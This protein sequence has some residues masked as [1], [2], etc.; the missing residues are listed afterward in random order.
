MPAE[1]YVYKKEVDWFLFNYGLN[2]PIQHQVKFKQIAGRFIE[3]DHAVSERK[4]L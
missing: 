4:I 1:N 2:I 3:A